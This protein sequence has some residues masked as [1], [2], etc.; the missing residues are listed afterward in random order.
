[1]TRLPRIAMLLPMLGFVIAATSSCA[2]APWIVTPGHPVVHVLVLSGC[3]STMEGDKD[4]ANSYT[5][6]ELVPPDPVSGRICRYRASLAE[7]D[8]TGAPG[9]LYSSVPLTAVVAVHLATVIDAINTAA[10]QGTV[11]CP[12][13][14]GSAS[15][16]A[17]EY[18]SRSD[19]DLWFSDS[20]C[21]TLDNGRVGA[22]EP[23]NPSFYNSFLT[24]MN[25]LAPQHYP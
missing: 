18:A 15:I 17:F 13:D 23:G 14:F 4:V 6:D 21:E 1:M 24:L 2:T 8:E 10:P 9:S 22:F 16:I 19:V 7:P 5:G 20:G 25:Q 11:A 3:A 12:A